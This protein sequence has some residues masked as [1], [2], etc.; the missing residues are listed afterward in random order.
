ML[1]LNNQFGYSYK[2]ILKK[3]L[4]AKQSKIPLK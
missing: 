4:K 2:Q 1:G 3:E